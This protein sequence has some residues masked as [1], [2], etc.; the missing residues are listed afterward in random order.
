MAKFLN[1]ST[2][3]YFLKEMIKGAS[4]RSSHGR[5]NGVENIVKFR[6]GA[7]ILFKKVALT[8]SPTFGLNMNSSYHPATRSL[9]IHLAERASTNYVELTDRLVG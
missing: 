3:S 8:H 7:Y 2:T 9:Y 1:T 4:D 6:F 5:K